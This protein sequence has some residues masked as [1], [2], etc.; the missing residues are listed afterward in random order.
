[1]LAHGAS[2]PRERATART[3]PNRRNAPIG[4]AA[5]AHRGAATLVASSKGAAPV[6]TP[7]HLQH[8]KDYTQMGLFPPSDWRSGLPITVSFLETL[9]ADAARVAR[10]FTAHKVAASPE[11]S[12]F[13]HRGAS[14]CEEF[15]RTV[16]NLSSAA[17]SEVKQAV[18]ALQGAIESS[19][20]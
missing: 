11:L 17:T 5:A 18:D 1:M 13:C 9:G 14:I 15:A 20:P 12:A 4:E 19:Q 16:S 6:M 7:P 8:F 10:S 2:W 3:A